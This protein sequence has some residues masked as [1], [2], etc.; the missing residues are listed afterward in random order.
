[1]LVN[2]TYVDP[3][4]IFFLLEFVVKVQELSVYEINEKDV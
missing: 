4:I 1:L 3:L 2:N